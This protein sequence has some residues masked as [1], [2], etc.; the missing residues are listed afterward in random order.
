[1]SSSL[2]WKFNF[3]DV[4]LMKEEGKQRKIWRCCKICCKREKQ[5][6]HKC[7]VC[8]TSHLN[9]LYKCAIQV[10]I[11]LCATLC[12]EFQ[13]HSTLAISSHFFY[14]DTVE[15]PAINFTWVG[16]GSKWSFF[17]SIRNLY[18]FFTMRHNRAFLYRFFWI[19]LADNVKKGLF[20]AA[21]WATI[22]RIAAI[23]SRKESKQ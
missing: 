21:T 3:V 10:T 20:P 15:T 8:L 11:G 17:L 22:A 23:S 7:D 6:F 19:S 12:K 2:G 1:M 9:S 13:G 4:K 14:S 16:S 5:V 18:A